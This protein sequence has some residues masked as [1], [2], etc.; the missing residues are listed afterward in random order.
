MK[1]LFL[2]GSVLFLMTLCSSPKKESVNETASSDPKIQ[3]YLSQYKPYP[4][5]FDASGYDEKDK[6]ILQKLVTAAQYLDT[7]YWLQNSKYGLHLRDSLVTIGGDSQTTDLLTLVNRNAGP[8]ELLNHYTPFMGN[9]DYY[10]GHELYPHGMTAEQFDAYVATLSEE[11]KAE[12][13]YPYTVIREDGEGGYKAVRYHEE[14]NEYIQPIVALLNEVAELTDNESFAR[15]LRLKAEALT[16]DNYYDAD[17]AWIDMEDSKFDMVFGP[18]ETYSDGVKGVK[19]MYEALIEVIDVEASKDLEKYTAYLAEME[20]NLPIP[21]EYKSDASGLTAKFVVVNDIIR[22]GEAG[23]GYQAVAA[24]LPNDPAVHAAKGTKKTFW[25]NML[26]ARFNGIIVPVSEVL[27][28]DR[29]LPYLS[30][31]GFFQFVLMHE[32]CH[33]I[34]PRTVKT[35]PNKGLAANASIGPNYN[36][37]EEA[38]ADIVGLYSLKYLMDKGVVKSS[39]KEEFY[40]SYLG[41]MFRSIRFGLNEAHGKAAAI[42]L[43]YL[44]ENGG[45]NYNTETGKWS[46][47]FEHFEEGIKKLAAEM[48]ILEGDGDNAK[49]QE[50]FDAWT[51]E[52][53]ALA[54]A[55]Q[56]TADLPIDVL[57]VRSIK[58]E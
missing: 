30:D 27:I 12:F 6:L 23:V 17:V 51:K 43:N 16:T 15:F 5:D 50:F 18:F 20:E 46:I 7:I 4:M 32:I 26:I 38:K 47:D 37:L 25:K 33:A 36:A 14:Y 35:G 49:V 1:R 21:A 58:W 39:R 28:E 55:M 29:Q 54:D 24:N 52:T 10:P 34:G 8:F 22:T 53:P 13:M 31:E 41:S 40:V 42:S 19:A 2:L 57:P 48:L 44:L 3:A 9:Q 56:K 11:E 45:I